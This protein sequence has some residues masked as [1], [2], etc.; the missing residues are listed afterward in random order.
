[1]KKLRRLYLIAA[2]DGFRLLHTHEPDLAEIALKAPEAAAPGL[3]GGGSATRVAEE[4]HHFCHKVIAAL[5][6]EWARGSYDQIVI[7]AGP[8]MLGE[9][10]S[11]LPKSLQPHVAAELHKDLF[12]IPAH[13]LAA[14]FTEVSEA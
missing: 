14:H 3:E 11:A 6:A 7:A 4:R 12:K 9:L 8:K 2:D 10:R 1:M 13:E 5:E